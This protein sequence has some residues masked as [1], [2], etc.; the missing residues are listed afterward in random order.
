M[1][2][3]EA[4]SKH[5]NKQILDAG[6]FF[7]TRS[8]FVKKFKKAH[9]KKPDDPDAVDAEINRRI[10][11]I[12]PEKASIFDSI[13]A[14]G[15]IGTFIA[16]ITTDVLVAK[17]HFDNGD[18][19]WFAL[20]CSFIILPSLIMQIFSCKWFKEDYLNQTWWTYL[21]HFFQLGTIERYAIAFWYGL[22]TRWI[23]PVIHS[24]YIRYLTE[25]RDITLLRLF[26]G[27]L[28]AAPQM[29]LQ[30]YILTSQK[31]FIVERDWLTATSAVMSI[32]S[33]SWAIVS[34]SQTLRLC[35]SNK[36][37]SLCGY[38]FQIWYRLFMVASRVVVLVL[39][40]SAFREYIFVFIF[41]HIAVMF[42]WLSCMDHVTYS[43]NEERDEPFLEKIFTLIV[44]IIYIFC[45][46]NIHPSTTKGQISIY[47]S[48]MFVEN[49][50]LIGAWF[51]YRTLHG[52]LMYAAFGVVFG[53][54]FL[55]IF[56]MLL[57]YKYFHPSQDITAG[58]LCCSCFGRRLPDDSE[59]NNPI[60]DN[61]SFSYSENDKD[62]VI[63]NVKDKKY[64]K[65]N[66]H[67]MD[68]SP[69]TPRSKSED[70]LSI[71]IELVR[72]HSPS[73]AA[74]LAKSLSR[75][76]LRKSLSR[77]RN[78]DEGPQERVE[79]SPTKYGA[80]GLQSPTKTSGKTSKIR[81]YETLTG[82]VTYSSPEA[83]AE[84]VLKNGSLSQCCASN[85]GSQSSPRWEVR[86][87]KSTNP[88]RW[89]EEKAV[90]AD[91]A[92][93]G[94]LQ[95]REKLQQHGRNIVKLDENENKAKNDEKQ[96]LM[97]R[98]GSKDDSHMHRTNLSRVKL[99]RSRAN[100]L[101]NR[102]SIRATLY[103]WAK[104]QIADR[105]QERIS[106]ENRHKETQP[107]KQEDD[108]VSTLV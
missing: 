99:R 34:Y 40:A 90:L 9:P 18:D 69:A 89:L 62:L 10:G 80:L 38:C 108:H 71:P 82:N 74:R 8:V 68:H 46:L 76:K 28:E 65:F 42:A 20:T 5:D 83:D 100:S 94:T 93:L 63:I 101:P 58:W 84:S 41:G 36:G 104:G 27:F 11:E 44:S 60:L 88:G 43:V 59:T 105:D 86:V 57:Y 72:P 45:F 107:R 54:F 35:L 22:R 95:L 47:Y 91:K 1:A 19:V 16:D 55:G 33:L 70:H 32:I 50:G 78:S 39:F 31:E 37:M 23:V 52:V 13:F 106:I 3:E 97:K 85:E 73:R 26:E 25:W 17:Q 87:S 61:T 7:M 79:Y 12:K 103:S 56:C 14:V 21:L 67:P 66:D 4:K 96:P 81:S 92:E 6:D 2:N 75:D 64:T 51:P 77:E 29:V 30:L 53:G 48:V 98:Q 15:A 24:D 49:A 102:D